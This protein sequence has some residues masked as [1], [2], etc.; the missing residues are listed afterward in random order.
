MTH[1]YVAEHHIPSDE[2]VA[3]QPFNIE[4]NDVDR[5]IE[6]WK[7]LMFDKKKSLERLTKYDG[8]SSS[9]LF[10]NKVQLEKAK[11]IVI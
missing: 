5:T 6:E 9:A 7:G 8:V 11:K 3:Q 2:P 10:S 1:P 4:D